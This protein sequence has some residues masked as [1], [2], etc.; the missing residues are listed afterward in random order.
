MDWFFGWFYELLYVL[1]KSICYII[2]FIREIFLKLVGIETVKIDGE[3]HDLLT[4]FLTTEGVRNAFLGVFLI[5]VILLFVF[6]GVAIIKSEAAD[7]QH[8]K[9]KGQIVAKSLQSFITFLIVPFVLLA[10]ITLTNVVM[11]GINA[12][13]SGAAVSGS[14]HVSLGGQILVTSGYDAYI[15]PA[16]SRASIEQMFITGKLNYN[17]LSVVE[18][19]YKLADLNF[20]VGLASSLVILVMFVLSTIS[21]IQRIFDIVLLY[22]VSPVSVSTIPLDDGQRFKLWREMMIS[23][24]LGCYGIVL[25]MNLFFLIIPKIS[26]IAFFDSNFKNGIVQLLFV[27]GGAFAVTKANMVIAQLTGTMPEDRKRSSYSPT[28]RRARIWQKRLRERLVL[29]QV[30]L[31]A[32]RISFPTKNAA[33]AFSITFLRL[34]IRKG[35]G[36]TSVRRRLRATRRQS[37]RKRKRSAMRRKALCDLQ[38][39]PSGL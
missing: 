34:F 30:C 25:A 2:D 6:V 26:G 13:M 28:F 14:T 22:I 1:Q 7:P 11:R 17:N 29:P 15:G 16:G 9:T 19:Y 21:F 12:S 27:I 5:G 4:Y 33:Q 39:C 8:K 24:V 38:P 31:S 23:K 20:F 32:A 35:T 10:G 37:L 36:T 3:K 18:E